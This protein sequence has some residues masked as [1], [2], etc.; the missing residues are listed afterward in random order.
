MVASVPRWPQTRCVPTT[1]AAVASI[2]VTFTAILLAR[3]E[4]FAGALLWTL[5]AVS[6]MVL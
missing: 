6:G 2:V 1:G 5:A 3:T 4:V